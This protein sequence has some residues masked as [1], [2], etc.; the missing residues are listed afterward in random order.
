MKKKIVLI[1]V[2]VMFFIGAAVVLAEA[3]PRIEVSPLEYDFGE[4]ELGTSS[5]LFL[6]I[7]NIGDEILT[8]NTFSLWGSKEISVNLSL[9]EYKINPG[10]QVEI[11][12]TFS[13]LSEG[14]HEALLMFESN[15]LNAIEVRVELYGTGVVA[16]VPPEQ[17]I[18]D[19]LDFFDESVASGTLKGIGPPNWAELRLI[20]M[21]YLLETI[22]LFIDWDY[23][24]YACYLLD[25]AYQ[26]TDGHFEPPDWVK[27]EAAPELAAMI[28]ELMATLDCERFTLNSN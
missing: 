28:Q 22:Q 6:S 26:F 23:T 16:S 12:I 24:W 4:V 18:S 3:T 19:I 11:E 27:G 20:A 15:D 9:L 21:K 8:V 7:I 2:L 5:T 10:S 25:R 17:Q 1:S 13:P 14:Y